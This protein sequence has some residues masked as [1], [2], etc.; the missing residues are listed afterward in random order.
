MNEREREELVER[1]SGRESERL[2]GLGLAELLGPAEFERQC[3]AAIA[4]RQALM[5]AYAERLEAMSDD[6]LRAHAADAGPPITTAWDLAQAVLAGRTGAVE[7]LLRER[8]S[9][10]GLDW[11]VERHGRGHTRLTVAGDDAIMAYVLWRLA[12]GPK[13]SELHARGPDSLGPT[14][15]RP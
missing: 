12:G 7:A 5:D 13:L 14:Y 10:P 4:A 9:G 6:E 1:L 8:R 3:Q 11:R 2:D 15:G